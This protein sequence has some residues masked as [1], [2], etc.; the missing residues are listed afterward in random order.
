MMNRLNLLKVAVLIFVASYANMSNAQC[1]LMVKG[2]LPKLA[3]Y[4]NNSQMNSTV[5][6]AG[7]SAELEMTFYSG[8]EYRLF[9]CSQ[10]VLGKIGFKLMDMNKNVLFE[11]KKDNINYFDF[12][13]QATQQMIV[14]VSAPA[15][16]NKDMVEA[17]CVSILVGFKDPK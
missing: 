4:T 12:N 5:L 8:Q 6:R 10:E 14:E 7:E 13:V 15:G 16:T 9:I 11:N 3:P 2:C 17:G 1:K